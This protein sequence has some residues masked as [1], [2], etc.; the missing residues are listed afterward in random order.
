M[1]ISGESMIPLVIDE[2]SLV[3][4]WRTKSPRKGDQIAPSHPTLFP[5]LPERVKEHTC[6]G[7]MCREN[8]THWIA[9]AGRRLLYTLPHHSVQR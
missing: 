7:Q 3:Y 2:L 9:F 8:I 1:V 6:F 5:R 4:R